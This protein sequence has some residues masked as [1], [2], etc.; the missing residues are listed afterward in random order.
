[1]SK[2][3]KVK[4]KKHY[5]TRYGHKY[6]D[7]RLS[8]KK[9]I[10]EID[11]LLS[12]VEETSEEFSYDEIDEKIK[13]DELTDDESLVEKKKKRS[14][15]ELSKPK[16][17]SFKLVFDITNIDDLAIVNLN[18]FDI[19]FSGF[20]IKSIDRIYKKIINFNSKS[21]ESDV[22]L[23]IS[24][25]KELL[26]KNDIKK[27]QTILN[28]SSN[29]MFFEKMML[30]KLASNEALKSVKMNLL[31]QYPEFKK[32]FVYDILKQPGSSHN[33]NIYNIAMVDIMKYY[34]VVNWFKELK[35]NLSH[36]SLGFDSIKRVILKQAL[37]PKKHN[38]LIIN[39]KEDHTELLS[40]DGKVIEGT[41]IAPQGYSKFVSAISES[42]G[43]EYD[44]A[45]ND[46][47]DGNDF[48]EILL[49]KDRKNFIRKH[50][51]IVC[52]E[53]KRIIGEALL[54]HNYDEVYLNIEGLD[55]KLIGDCLSKYLQF[56]ISYFNTKDLNSKNFLSSLGATI[57]PN[58]TVDFDFPVNVKLYK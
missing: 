16:F 47:K 2:N 3:K 14:T 52:L 42:F 27:P 35:L 33:N 6:H 7:D 57:K 36:I 17:G 56:D 13:A 4:I 10:E 58:K 54:E 21:Y 31:K 49:M 45:Y 18:C 30:P 38:A 5:D 12:N 15:F 23:M 9:T 26:K 40:Y 1:M 32:R 46:L 51:S 41:R 39:M 37:L 20:K 24:E 19:S 22:Y 43:I 50:L 29:L 8:S 44:K 55:N 34:K 53:C 48:D 11:E 25:I 28:F